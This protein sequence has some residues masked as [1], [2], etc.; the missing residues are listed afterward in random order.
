MA[1]VGLGVRGEPRPAEAVRVPC[2]VLLRVGR[3][4]GRQ[5]CRSNFRRNREGV[6]RCAL[7]FR[8]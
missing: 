5:G 3:P 2:M 6:F 4:M 7:T 1:P 8:L